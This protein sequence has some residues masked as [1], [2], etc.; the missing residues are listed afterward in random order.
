MGNINGALKTKAC[1]LDLTNMRPTTTSPS[2][3]AIS[4]EEHILECVARMENGLLAENEG[5]PSVQMR[6]RINE[7]VHI[8][9][10]GA[11]DHSMLSYCFEVECLLL[12]WHDMRKW[13]S[14]V[15][16]A[17]ILIQRPQLLQLSQR[18]PMF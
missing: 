17:W 14:S 16:P 8:K 3:A 11:T 13:G 6:L 4:I 5:S 9:C 1:I 10:V 15:S 2:Y 18:A 7:G 12:P